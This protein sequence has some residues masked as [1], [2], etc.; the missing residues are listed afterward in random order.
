M[1]FSEGSRSRL[2]VEREKRGALR[3]I[4]AVYTK[5]CTSF[6]VIGEDHSKINLTV[7]HV[8]QTLLVRG[9]TN[10]S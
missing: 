5:R 8:N 7:L 3:V 10:I 6:G 4:D 2:L 1:F 9:L